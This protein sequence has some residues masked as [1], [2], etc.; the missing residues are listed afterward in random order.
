[1]DR[2]EMVKILGKHFGVK[3]KYLEVPS[4]QYQIETPKETYIL[5]QLIFLILGSLFPDID[6]PYSI[7]GRYNL[8]AQV[9]SHRRFTHTVICCVIVSSII[10][11][12]EWDIGVSFAFGYMTHLL[13]DTL[14]P[15]GI[16]WFYPYSKKY[17]RL[18]SDNNRYGFEGMIFFLCLVYL[19]QF[20]RI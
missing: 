8:L 1:M 12:Y 5:F 17:Y 20:K 13:G 4:F 16:M 10:C 18:L 3:P 11:I 14:T 6:T 2:K 19:F 9:L 15:M 7:L